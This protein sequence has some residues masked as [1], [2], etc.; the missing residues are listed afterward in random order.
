[1]PSRDSEE[2]RSRTLKSV[3]QEWKHRR[4]LRRPPVNT[5]KGAMEGDE[6]QPTKH[7]GR[8]MDGGQKATDVDRAIEDD[9]GQPITPPDG[10]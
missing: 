7:R 2:K 9:E 6:G 10:P 5:S 4:N 1:M 8:A 3:I